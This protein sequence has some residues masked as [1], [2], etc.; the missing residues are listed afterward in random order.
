MALATICASVYLPPPRGPARITAWGKRS[1][2]SICA[3]APSPPPNC[4]GNQRIP[5]FSCVRLTFSSG[6][7]HAAAML[8]ADPMA[9]LVA[10]LDAAIPWFERLPAPLPSLDLQRSPTPHD[11]GMHDV[12]PAAGVDHKDP[13]PVRVRAILR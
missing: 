12:G 2:S 5:K 13:G 7:S 8:A 6:S 9:L 4:R 3:Q 1:R 10:L 11:I